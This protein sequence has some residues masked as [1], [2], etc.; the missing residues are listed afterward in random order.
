M[1]TLMPGV[2]GALFRE[3]D[4]NVMHEEDT[5]AR[6]RT[7][8]NDLCVAARGSGVSIEQ[9]I[10]DAKEVFAAL[11]ETRAF[12]PYQ[13]AELQNLLVSACIQAYFD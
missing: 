5:K 6:F 7:A 2:L 13:R 1:R 11:P 9:V 10:I 12:P 4:V 3:V 8:V